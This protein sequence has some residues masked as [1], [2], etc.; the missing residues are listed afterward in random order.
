MAWFS[1]GS[2]L[3]YIL[4][5]CTWGPMRKAEVEFESTL[6]EIELEHGEE[7]ADQ[8]IDH[9]AC[10][11]LLNFF[12]PIL[13]TVLMVP[14]VLYITG[15]GQFSKGSGSMSVYSG[16]M[17]GTVVSFIWFRVRGIRLAP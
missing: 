5:G 4:S 9:P 13:S 11:S 14:I 12:I 3:F 10:N 7:D 8:V 15:D 2:V 6:T 16:V 1:L 17:F